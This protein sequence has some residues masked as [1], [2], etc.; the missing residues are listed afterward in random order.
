[1]KYIILIRLKDTVSDPVGNA[2]GTALKN[3]GH[4]VKD[5]RVGRLVQLESDGSRND[6]EKMCQTILVNPIIEDYEIV[7][8]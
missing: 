3:L 8:K 1:M 7:E 4:T 5:V 2:V 6:V